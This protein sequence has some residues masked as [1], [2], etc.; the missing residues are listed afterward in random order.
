MRVGRK[1]AGSLSPGPAE[2]SSVR[3]SPGPARPGK[4]KRNRRRAPR[5]CHHNDKRDQNPSCK[6]PPPLSLIGIII[7]H[8]EVSRVSTIKLTVNGKAVS[9]DVE[10]RT[11]LVH[12]LRENLN[13]TRTHVCCHTSQCC[14]CVVHTDRPAVIS[15]TVL[16]APPA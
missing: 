13:L 11:L 6:F 9:A 14:A 1:F 10:E 5:G 4:P 8:R 2:P 3:H 12:L 15:C 16:A 7:K